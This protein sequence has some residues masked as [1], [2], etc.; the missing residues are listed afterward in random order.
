MPAT[1]WV[2]FKRAD[3]VFLIHQIHTFRDEEI[4]DMLLRGQA[5]NHC[6]DVPVQLGYIPQHLHSPA[7][8]EQTIRSLPLNSMKSRMCGPHIKPRDVVEITKHQLKHGRVEALDILM[9]EQKGTSRPSP[10][11]PC[12]E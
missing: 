4:R 5:A 8:E 6:C 9:D 1:L 3:P 10:K 2:F 7:P 11:R 12:Q